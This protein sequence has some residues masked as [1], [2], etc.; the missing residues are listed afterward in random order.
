MWVRALKTFK[1]RYGSIKA[2]EK[3]NA[4]PGY[5]TALNKRKGNPMVKILS[6]RDE[7]GPTDD[8]SKGDPP[9]HAGKEKPGAQGRTPAGD[10]GQPPAAGT[11]IT[12]RSLPA[13]PVSRKRI[14]VPS[15]RGGRKGKPTPRK[16]KVKTTV[17]IRAPQAPPDA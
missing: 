15:Q 8:R 5:V 10:T 14:A 13:G 4:E 7:P 9:G 2:G 12:S 17:T 3:F 11:G 1:G 6:D 16:G